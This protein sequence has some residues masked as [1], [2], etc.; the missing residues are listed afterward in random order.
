MTN[1]RVGQKAER[2]RKRDGLR[3]RRR[4]EMSIGLK[5]RGKGQMIGRNI[6]GYL[7]VQTRAF[8]L[9]THL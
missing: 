5:L 3:H 6:E 2:K 8:F 4:R 1:K 7:K 9:P